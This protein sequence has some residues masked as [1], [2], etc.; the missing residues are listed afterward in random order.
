[1]FKDFSTRVNLR[2][3][4]GLQTY[5]AILPRFLSNK[6]VLNLVMNL[7]RK[8]IGSIPVGDSDFF[9]PVLVTC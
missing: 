5:H 7:V 2:R 1:M 8:V 3:K 9:C 6:I 4:D